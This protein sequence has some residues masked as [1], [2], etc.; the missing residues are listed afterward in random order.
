M[1]S[2][3]DACPALI[4]PMASSK[5][6]TAMIDM[7]GPNISLKPRVRM[8]KRICGGLSHS[9]ISVSSSV[10]PLTIVGA[11]YLVDGTVSPPETM[12]PLMLSNSPLT[13]K[14]CA[15]VGGRAKESFE[16]PSGKNSEI[17]IHRQSPRSGHNEPGLTFPSSQR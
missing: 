7:M 13:R 16:A 2:Y 12:V 11:V 6:S 15:S 10:T 4:I 14:I 1:N 8:A 17:L 9:D 5:S 3:G